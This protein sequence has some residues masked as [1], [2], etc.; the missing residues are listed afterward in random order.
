MPG[1]CSV[2]GTIRTLGIADVWVKEISGGPEQTMYYDN[3]CIY[4][5]RVFGS[6]NYNPAEVN[7]SGICKTFA[8]HYIQVPTLVPF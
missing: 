1:L 8:L 4:W 3:T 5:C 7:C 2:M 6:H